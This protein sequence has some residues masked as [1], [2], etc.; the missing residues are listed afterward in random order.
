MHKFLIYTHSKNYKNE[1]LY[2]STENYKLLASTHK[3]QIMK[4]HKAYKGTAQFLTPNTYTFL[5]KF[6]SQVLF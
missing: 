5:E 6:R 2:Q 3:K 1:T 4:I